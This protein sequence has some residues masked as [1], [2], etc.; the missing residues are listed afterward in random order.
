MTIPKHDK[1]DSIFQAI[2]VTYPEIHKAI[3]FYYF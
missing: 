2:F 3:Q 1:R